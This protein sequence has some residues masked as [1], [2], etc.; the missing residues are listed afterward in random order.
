MFEASLGLYSEVL[1]N[2]DEMLQGELFSTNENFP[3]LSQNLT[4]S[5]SGSF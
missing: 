2:G 5:F 3:L 4:E 1:E